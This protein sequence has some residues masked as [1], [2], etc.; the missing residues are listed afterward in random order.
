MKLKSN[1]TN[2]HKRTRKRGG[3]GKAKS[4]K[5]KTLTFNFL[6]IRGV[7]SKIHD[8]N[9]HLLSQDVAIFGLAETFLKSDDRPHSL[10]K[11]Y[12]WIGKSRKGNKSKGGIGLC[13]SR[14][15]TVLDENLSNTKI[16]SFE[17]F[18][19][20]VRIDNMKVA[21][22]IVYFPN[23]G[24]DKEK[25]DA[26]FYELLENIADFNNQGYGV[27]LMGDFNGKCLD[28][29]PSTGKN[30]FKSCSSYNGDRLLQFT[31]ASDLTILNSL[32]CCVGLHTRILNNQRSPIDYFLMSKDL[33]PSV[34]N[35]FIDE[36][37]EFDLH[38]DHVILTVKFKIENTHKPSPN[39]NQSVLR[40]KIND[41]TDW[42]TFQNNLQNAFDLSPLPVCNDINL[43]RV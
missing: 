20:L 16:D 7:S 2:V 42:D 3:K 15:L 11:D 33:T 22:G 10:N 1:L 37:G 4:K 23:D 36:D 32:N 14:N 8:L 39:N 12:Q 43:E 25:T 21:V 35:M 28:K 26:L 17:R 18:W 31:E 5:L 13:I 24:I 9:R 6:N 30:V 40:W 19:S 38:S 34:K 41:K 29:C 27:M